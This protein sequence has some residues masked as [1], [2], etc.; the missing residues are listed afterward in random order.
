MKISKLKIYKAIQN[1]LINECKKK[2]I[3]INFNLDTVDFFKKNIIDSLDFLNLISNIEKK[4]NIE[5]DLSNE[6]PS[7]LT[8]LNSLTKMV[9]K[10]V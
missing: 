1:Y 6:N 7:N 4:L 8:K 3:K 5:I 2:K 10:K 9:H